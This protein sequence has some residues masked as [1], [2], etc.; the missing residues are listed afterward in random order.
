[1]FIDTGKGIRFRGM[2][3]CKKLIV[4]LENQLILFQSFSV[5]NFLRR[6]LFIFSAEDFSS[7]ESIPSLQ[8]LNRKR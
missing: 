4:A 5:Q 1:M 2:Q 8:T 6:R 3:I 7:Y